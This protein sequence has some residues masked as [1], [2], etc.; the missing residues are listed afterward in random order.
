MISR[1]TLRFWGN[2]AKVCAL[3]SWEATGQWQWGILMVG[4]LLIV[5]GW[6][7]RQVLVSGEPIQKMKRVE[8]DENPL[9]SWQRKSTERSSIIPFIMISAL[10]LLHRF[11]WK[12]VCAAQ[13]FA[14]V[15]PIRFSSYLSVVCRAML[16]RSFSSLTFV[17]RL[18]RSSVSF[19]TACS[20]FQR[21]SLSWSRSSTMVWVHIHKNTKTNR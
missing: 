8:M 3:I 5:Q 14:S 19:L 7:W 21:L 16:W 4:W 9:C 18:F 13:T 10:E 2:A 12:L 11:M 20:A 15:C 1:H 17:C 6:D